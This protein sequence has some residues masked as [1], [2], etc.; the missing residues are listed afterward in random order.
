VILA[1]FWHSMRLL[2]L[3]AA[4]LITTFVMVPLNVVIPGLA[5]P[6]PDLRGI[7]TAY[8]HPRLSYGY[9]PDL[10]EWL[11]V[12]FALGVALTVFA[13]GYRA[14]LH[15]YYSRLAQEARLEPNET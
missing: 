15:R 10:T 6:T 12:I 9:F 5:Y 8:Q 7:A 4:L 1:F 2:A 14:L 11:V 13:V 3:A